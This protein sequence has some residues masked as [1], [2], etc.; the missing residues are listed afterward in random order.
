MFIRRKRKSRPLTFGQIIHKLCETQ[1]NDG[2][3]L[4]VLDQIAQANQKTF[5]TER[6][7]FGDIINDSRIIWRE[8]LQHW[9][10]EPLTFVKVAGHWSEIPFEVEIVK[11]E[12]VC[13]GRIDGVVKSPNKLRWMRE[14]K[15]FKQLLSEEYRWKA[16]QSAVYHRIMDMMG[17]KECEGTLWEF[18]RSKPPTAPQILKSGEVSERAIDTLPTKIIETL[19]PLGIKPSTGLMA[20]AI[21]NRAK[22]FQRIFM[23]RKDEVIDHVWA[24]FVQTSKEMSRLFGKSKTR[25]IDKHC[26]W[27]EYAPLCRA[28]MTG[29][30]VD[31]LLE[32]E[33]YVDEADY[34]EI[35]AD[36]EL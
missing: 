20:D 19:K 15:T 6:E 16:V 22:Y 9:A 18:I 11:G 14:I 3:P 26:D 5:A 17:W 21:T 31:H 24:D 36:E 25:T 29:G 4:K 12:I 2:E 34:D 10:K 23:A 28:E 30:D 33:Y 27:C 32:R 13:K 1:A 8:Y 7:I 35:T